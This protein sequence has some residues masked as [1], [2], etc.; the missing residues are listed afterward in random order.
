MKTKKQTAKATFNPYAIQTATERNI[1]Q[2][3]KADQKQVRN[4][5]SKYRKDLCAIGC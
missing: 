3:Y 1:L 2:F 5:N 4:F